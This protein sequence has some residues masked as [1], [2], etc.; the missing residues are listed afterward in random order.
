MRIIKKFSDIVLTFLVL[1][2]LIMLWYL[3]SL[4]IS[5]PYLFPSPIDVMNA[6]IRLVK[7]RM[8]LSNIVYS[9]LRVLLGFSMGVVLGLFLGFLV[10]TFKFVKRTIYPLIIFV[11]VTPSIVF[12]PL[13]M[14]W[15]GLTDLLP[16][17]AVV[18]CTSFPLAYAI[19]SASKNIDP[20]IIDVALTLGATRKDIILKIVMPLSITHV[21]SMLKFELGHSWRIVFITEYLALTTGLG[22]LMFLAYSTIHVDEI[23]ALI[24]IIGLLALTLQWIIEHIESL[25]V[26]KWGYIR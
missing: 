2:I 15:I 22:S 11:A 8:L 25:I 12:I 5:L 7:Q 4:V 24:I 23:I 20:E 21:A 9:L 14:L 26:K 1:A 6:F 19:V 16:I 10:V 3:M 17:T 18:I 13:L